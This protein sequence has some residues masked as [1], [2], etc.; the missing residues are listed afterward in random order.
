MNPS[1]EPSGLGT[2]LPLDLNELVFR[3]GMTSVAKWPLNEIYKADGV[4][5]SCKEIEILTFW[6]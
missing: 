1:V 4:S 2:I 5:I 6:R 3:S